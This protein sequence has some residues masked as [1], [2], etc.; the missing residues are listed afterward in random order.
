MNYDQLIQ[1]ALNEVEKAESSKSLEQIRV[2]YFGKNGSVTELLKQL[3]SLSV[4]EK[5]EVGKKL[6]S[7]KS[8]FFVRLEKI[9]FDLE[10][11]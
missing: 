5:K 7:F 4:E 2:K 11:K 9:K 8:D 3:S 6:N 1:S 10:K